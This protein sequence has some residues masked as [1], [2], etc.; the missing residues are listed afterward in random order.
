M[1][2]LALITLCFDIP[3]NLFALSRANSKFPSSQIYLIVLYE[4]YVSS[5]GSISTNVLPIGR[6][7]EINPL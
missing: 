4:S 3:L 6:R 5:K 2:N 7:I 1:N